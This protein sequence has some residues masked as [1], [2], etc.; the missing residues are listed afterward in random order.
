MIAFHERTSRE[1][2]FSS[3]SWRAV[4]S[5]KEPLIKVFKAAVER[6]D[7]ERKWRHLIDGFI[8]IGGP[9]DGFNRRCWS[10]VRDIV[11]VAVANLL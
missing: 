1:V 6:V 11:L 8:D 10:V 2:G 4:F 3:N 9:E 7:M 5:C